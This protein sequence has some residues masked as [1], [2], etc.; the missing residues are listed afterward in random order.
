MPFLGSSPARGLVGSADID[1][2]AVTLAKMAH[3]TAN[4]NISYDGSGVPVDA[5]LSA[6]KVLQVVQTVKTD[7]TSTTSTSFTD[8]TGM[9]VAITPAATSSKILV[10]AS[11]NFGNNG[12]ASHSH[13]RLMRDSTAISIGDSDSSNRVEGSVMM[14]AT[15]NSTQAHRSIV[16]LDSPSSTSEISCHLEYQTQ[17][18]SYAVFL[19]RSYADGDDVGQGRNASSITAMEIGA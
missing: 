17:N 18:G 16:F 2:N 12:T 13:C 14:W 10:V 15:N 11:L 19:N 8:I 3:G 9:A 5:A 1:D 6:G 4:Q 7:T